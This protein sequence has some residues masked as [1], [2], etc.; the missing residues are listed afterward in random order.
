MLSDSASSSTGTAIGLVI[1]V[2]IIGCLIRF[3][4]LYGL[5]ALCI[6]CAAPAAKSETATVAPEVAPPSQEHGAALPSQGLQLREVQQ[7]PLPPPGY[8]MQQQQQPLQPQYA[9]QQAPMGY[10]PQQAPMGFAPQQAPLGYAPQPMGFAPQQQM[11][12][13]QQQMG[14]APQQMAYAPPQQ[15]AFAP[16]QQPQMMMM[17]M[18][19]QPQMV[20]AEK[21]PQVVMVQGYAPQQ[22]HM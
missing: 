3:A 6:C 5:A 1:A 2:G 22:G 11:G 13:L 20:L 12:Y 19:Q 10:A 14:Y 9:P 17:M 7:G 18:P 4:C 21:A 16:Q 8:S 15:M